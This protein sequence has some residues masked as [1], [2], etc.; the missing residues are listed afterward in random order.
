MITLD[1]LYNQTATIEHLSE[2]KVFR[3]D[4][5]RV[6][7]AN[8]RFIRNAYFTDSQSLF[9]VPAFVICDSI[10]AANFFK[11]HLKEFLAQWLF[12]RETSGAI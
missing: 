5:N 8:K 4:F 9:Q 6:D 3:I 12:T 11:T 7:L 2:L 1:M 10:G